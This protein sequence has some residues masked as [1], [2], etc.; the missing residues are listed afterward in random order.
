MHQGV[1]RDGCFTLPSGLISNKPPVPVSCIDPVRWRNTQCFDVG[2]GEAV[3]RWSMEYDDTGFPYFPD[4][5][6]GASRLT[7]N[8]DVE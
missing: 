3:T 4:T 5:Q 6:G 8:V 7:V 1:E 2:S